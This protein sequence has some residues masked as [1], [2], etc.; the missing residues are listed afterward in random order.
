MFHKACLI[1]IL[2]LNPIFSQASVVGLGSSNQHS[3]FQQHLRSNPGSI[4]LKNAII[5]KKIKKAD[6]YINSKYALAVKG[7]LL[8]DLTPSKYLFKEL[9]EA[10]K[11]HLFSKS[12]KKLVSES[13]YRLSNLER[14]QSNFWV[15][16]GLLFNLKYEP[17]STVFNPDIITSF[18]TQQDEVSNYS[19]DFNVKKIA[20]LSTNVFI[21]GS[22]VPSETKVHPSAIYHLNLFK[23]GHKNKFLQLS[24][25]ELIKSKK[26]RLQRLDLGTCKAPKFKTYQ[27]IKITEIFFSKDCIKQKKPSNVQLAEAS[28]TPTVGP[29]TTFA[30]EVTT[31]PLKKSFVKK[32]STLLIIAGVVVTAVIIASLNKKKDVNVVPVQ[33]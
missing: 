30:K 33:R 19:F 25:Q 26:I 15:K 23:D 3:D 28:S 4:S 20:A 9:A 12:T 8:D 27:G 14:T 13:Y 16:E 32:H 10:K 11:L 17:S 5:K 31:D 7:L 22:L 18:K 6:H 21:N 24:G 2:A 1:V 29:E